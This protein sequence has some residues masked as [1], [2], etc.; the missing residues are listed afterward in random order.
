ARASSIARPT[1]R[2]IPL[3]P[4]VTMPARPA[5]SSLMPRSSARVHRDALELRILEERLEALL[6][7]V[8]GPLVAAERQL[9]ATARAVAVDEHLADAQVADQSLGP[10]EVARP[11][12]GDQPVVG[13]V[14][15]RER[16]VVVGERGD[17]EHRPEDLLARQR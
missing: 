17:R 10:P 15:E 2:P 7:A 16:L 1:P 3:P 6:A 11:H 12:R 8:A 5:S 14:G 4:P 9:H 13:A